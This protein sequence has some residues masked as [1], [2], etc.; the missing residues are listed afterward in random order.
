[1]R[2][3]PYQRQKTFEVFYKGKSAKQFACDFVVYDKIILEVKAIKK[4]SDIE[5]AQVINYL[6]ASGLDLG[7]LINFGNNSLEFKRLVYTNRGNP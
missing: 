5:Q 4:I 6:K 1:L 7:L 3:I 2:K